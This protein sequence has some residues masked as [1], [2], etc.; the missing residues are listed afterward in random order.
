MR[1]ASDATTPDDLCTDV[2]AD[3]DEPSKVTPQHVRVSIE[4]GDKLVE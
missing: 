1:E 4:K 2:V 3:V